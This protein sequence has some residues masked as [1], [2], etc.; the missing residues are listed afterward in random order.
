MNGNAK[1][2]QN[3]DETKISIEGD[4]R[5]KNDDPELATEKWPLTGNPKPEYLNSFQNIGKEDNV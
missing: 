3:Y 5:A 4:K 1:E 2:R